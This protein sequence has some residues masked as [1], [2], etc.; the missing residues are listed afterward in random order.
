MYLPSQNFEH[1]LK[2]KHSHIDFDQC[3]KC[4][5]NFK[6]GDTAR[7]DMQK[8]SGFEVTAKEGREEVFHIRAD[9]LIFHLHSSRLVT[10]EKHIPGKLNEW[11]GDTT[12][13]TFAN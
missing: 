11:G 4:L 12:R 5:V 1:H 9:T 2:T 10:V 6:S 7:F 13:L 3:K 8:P